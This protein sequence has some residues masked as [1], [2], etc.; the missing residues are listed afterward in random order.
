MPRVLPRLLEAAPRAHSSDEDA[1]CFCLAG[2]NACWGQSEKG[3]LKLHVQKQVVACFFFP[4]RF[5]SHLAPIF[6]VSYLVY[7]YSSALSP[8]IHRSSRDGSGSRGYSPSAARRRR[9][10]DRGE[11]AA[12]YRSAVPLLEAA[13]G[14]LFPPLPQTANFAYPI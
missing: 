9:A 2:C 12:H 8:K 7:P 14:P 13:Q 10:R 4:R 6:P 3:M 1:F 5:V 11:G